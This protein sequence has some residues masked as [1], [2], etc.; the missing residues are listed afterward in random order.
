MQHFRLLAITA[1]LISCSEGPLKTPH[2]S[3]SQG[4]NANRNQHRVFIDVKDDGSLPKVDRDLTGDALNIKIYIYSELID[5]GFRTAA[6][7]EDKKNAE[8]HVICRFKHGLGRPV[9][10]RGGWIKTTYIDRCT[11]KII[12]GKTQ[13]LLLNKAFVRKDDRIEVDA[14]I[15]QSFAEWKG[16]REK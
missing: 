4:R 9:I 10:T 2:Q 14:F 15:T 5:L 12:D 11:L 6:S 7:D 13:R 1:L 3:V 8:L 16:Q